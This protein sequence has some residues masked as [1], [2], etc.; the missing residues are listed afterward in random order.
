MTGMDE[1]LGRRKTQRIPLRVPVLVTGAEPQLKSYSPGD[2]LNVSM[3]GALI[4]LTKPV[5]VGA[6][7]RIDI[8]NT[9]RHSLARVVRAEK[10]DGSRWKVA[11]AIQL[12]QPPGN[13][14]GVALPPV[15]WSRYTE[16]VWR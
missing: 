3:D 11:I 1:L 9:N 8:P 16:H 12:Q 15:S 5:P 2:T 14:W 6:T 10:A 4:Q 13:F 7:V